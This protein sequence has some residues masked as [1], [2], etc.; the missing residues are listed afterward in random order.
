MV[1]GVVNPM[2][3]DKSPTHP[4]LLHFCARLFFGVFV[5]L[6]SGADSVFR[7]KSRQSV[8]RSAKGPWKAIRDG[9]ESLRWLGERRFRW[10]SNRHV[11]KLIPSEN[12]TV[13]KKGMSRKLI[14]LSEFSNWWRYP[15]QER[16][17]KIRC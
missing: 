15:E 17:L 14:R 11:R 7:L 9:R 6:V 2:K 13:W 3:L 5:V 12:K 16:I 1:D 4:A 10:K 8:G